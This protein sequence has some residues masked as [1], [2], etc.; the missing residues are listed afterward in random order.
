M[1]HYVRLCLLIPFEELK[2]FASIQ[3]T[4]YSWVKSKQLLNNNVFKACSKLLEIK[5]KGIPLFP[6]SKIDGKQ[7]T[8]GN[9]DSVDK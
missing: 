9:L 1:K 4:I 6:S 2:Y 7:D 5:G 3:L 8:V